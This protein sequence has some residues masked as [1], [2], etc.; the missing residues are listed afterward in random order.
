MRHPLTSLA[1]ALILVLAVIGPPLLAL[2]ADRSQP[3]HLQADRASYNQRTGVST[4]SGHVEVSQGSMYLA[5][6]KATVYFDAA[7]SFQHME[8]VG[9][10]AHFRYQPSADK[11]RIEGV[12]DKVDYNAEKALVTV[13]GHAHFTQGRDQFSGDRIE[14]DLTKDVVHA[15]SAKGKR[16]Q[17]TIQPRRAK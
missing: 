15:S 16:I 2:P 8:A 14:Y 12:G 10:P 9:N 13:I 5:A 17:F 4:Y 6:D 3:I 11:P 1:T 7:G